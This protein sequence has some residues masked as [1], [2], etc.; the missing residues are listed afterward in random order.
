MPKGLNETREFQRNGCPFSK[1]DSDVCV[2]YCVRFCRALCWTRFARFR[3]NE[4]LGCDLVSNY[5]MNL[6]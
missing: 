5:E 3:F 4:A 1:V 6:F 2:Y